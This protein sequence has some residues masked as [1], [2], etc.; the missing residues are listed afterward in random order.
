MYTS[1]LLFALTGFTSGA[2]TTEAPD[3]HS[4]Y[5][6]AKKQGVSDRK[7]LA[8]FVASGKDGW[9][10]IARTGSLTKEINDVLKASYVCVYLDTQTTEGRRM[11][12]LLELERGPGLVISDHAGRLMAFHHQGALPPSDLKNYL[13]RFADSERVVQ[14]TEKVPGSSPT[15]Y[16]RSYPPST[17]TQPTMG[18]RSC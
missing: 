7:P 2:E 12:G 11:A 17:T 18:G 15:T 1:M 8:V 4:D 13:H 3:W 9:D 14:Q 10:K 6:V 16:S 5:A